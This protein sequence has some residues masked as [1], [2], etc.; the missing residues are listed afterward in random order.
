MVYLKASLIFLILLSVLSIASAENNLTVTDNNTFP[1]TQVNASGFLKIITIPV[2]GAIYL[3]N[4]VV[5]SG[6]YYNASYPVGVYLVSFGNVEGYESP[7]NQTVSISAG[8]QTNII[9]RYTAFVITPPDVTITKEVSSSSIAADEKIDIIIKIKNSG[10]I[11]AFNVNLNDSLPDCAVLVNGTMSWS[12]ELES[13]ESR[14]LDYE[15][16]A[17][18]AGLCIFNPSRITFADSAGNKFSKFSDEVRV[19][20]SSKPMHEPH[21]TIEKNVDKSTAQV[22]E[23]AVI[24]LKVKNDGSSEAINISLTDPIPACA[25]VSQGNN[26]WSGDLQ[27]D[28]QKVI[29]YIVNLNSPGL[30]SFDAA[31]ADYKDVNFNNYTKYSEPLNIYVKEKTVSEWLDTYAKPLVI[32]GTTIGSLVTIITVYRS[33]RNK[34]HKEKAEKK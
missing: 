20:V 7:E 22:D 26:N 19:L 5:G 16:S 17:T 6:L 14:I 30:C 11:K 29:T 33:L 25:A 27:P 3:D 2:D 34:V 8:N 28:E 10:T 21:L 12:G 32:I 1:I 13:S 4:Q 23:G 15:V 24:T 18:K 31:K 9:A